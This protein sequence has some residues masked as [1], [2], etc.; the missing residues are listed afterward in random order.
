MRWRHGAALNL[1]NSLPEIPSASGLRQRRDPGPVAIPSFLVG[2]LLGLLAAGA[3]SFAGPAEAAAPPTDLA[4]KA[5]FLSKFGGYVTW[6]AAARP[7]PRQPFM[8]CV[9]GSDPFGRI[10]DDAAQAE[11]IGGRSI[12]VRRLPDAGSSEACHIAFVR[13]AAPESTAALLDAFEA[14]P[15]LTVTDNGA[16]GPGGIIH[17]VRY[18]GRVRFRIDEA[19]AARRGLSINSRLLGIALSVRRER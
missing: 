10:L 5:G 14:R 18:R 4:V 11:H 7:A 3:L 2:R 19:A 1:G 13:G 6:P 8:L 15:V 12:V 17:F 9:I 16:G